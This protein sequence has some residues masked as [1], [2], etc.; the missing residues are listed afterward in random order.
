MKAYTD[1]EQSKK[2]IDILPLESADMHYNNGSCR[3][4]DYTEHFSAELMPYQ[5]ALHLMK[6]HKTNFMFQVIPCWSLSALIEEIPEIINFDDDESD[7]A[8][9]ILKENGLYYLSYG[10][11]LEHGKIE[12]EPQE[13][14]VD[15]CVEMIEKL[16][17]QK[18]L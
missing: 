14:F 7:Y 13:Y 10:N 2:L 6:I 5:E 18:L 11:L 15:A 8:L 16:H 9:E 4:V 3:G 1:L 17:K 12:I